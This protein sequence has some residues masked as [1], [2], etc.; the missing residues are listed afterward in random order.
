MTHMALNNKTVKA[1]QP[2]FP[3]C[4]EVFRVEEELQKL[5]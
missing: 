4:V 1:Q 5:F 3:V 2:P